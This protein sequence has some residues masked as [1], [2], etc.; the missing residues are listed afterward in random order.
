MMGLGWQELSIILIIILLVFGAGK[1]PEIGTALGRSTKQ[2]KAELG[3]GE[4]DGALG[5]SSTDG[6]RDPRNPRTHPDQT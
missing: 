6:A 5:A 3:S 1:L 2:F 4:S